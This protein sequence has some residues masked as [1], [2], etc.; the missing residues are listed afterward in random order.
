MHGFIKITQ[1]LLLLRIYVFIY[2]YIE[3][4]ISE[5]SANSLLY[6][7]DLKKPN[8]K[9]ILQNNTSTA[10]QQQSNFLQSI[11]LIKIL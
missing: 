6:L 9:W 7:K 3:F 1:S 8:Q 4:I 2:V 11:A 10:K 5:A